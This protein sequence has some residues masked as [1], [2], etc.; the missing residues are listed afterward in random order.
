LAIQTVLIT[1]THFVARTCTA[2]VLLALASCQY[3][4]EQSFLSSSYPQQHK[5]SQADDINRAQLT[6]A[7]GAFN[8]WA[9]RSG[10]AEAL[11]DIADGKPIK[12][13]IRSVAG[14]RE[15]IETPGLTNCHPDRYD[16]PADARS[17][18]ASLGSDYSE[19]IIYTSEERARFRS[20][21]LFARAYNVT[22]FTM[23]RDEVLKICPAA[24]R[25]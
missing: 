12:L 3:S 18:F 13:Y 1:D 5:S 24:T 4:A 6:P 10:Q 17:T 23:R 9:G 2:L 15:V 20:A 25:D 7:G 21:T 19:S 8:P 16:V 14:E 11:A 22:M